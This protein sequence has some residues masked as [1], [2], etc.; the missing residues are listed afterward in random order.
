MVLEIAGGIILAAVL[1][2]ALDVVIEFI[3]DLF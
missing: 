2:S 1:L 3:A